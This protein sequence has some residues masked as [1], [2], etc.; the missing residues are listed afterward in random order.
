MSRT[1]YSIHTVLK[2][3]WCTARKLFRSKLCARTASARQTDT[4]VH[5]IHTARYTRTQY[6]LKRRSV[7]E[8]RARTRET[9]GVRLRQG[10]DPPSL[11][12]I[13]VDGPQRMVRAIDHQVREID[14]DGPSGKQQGCFRRKM[15]A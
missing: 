15:D 6:E 9:G 7:S 10:I 5:S 1:A 14:N 12:V 11:G 13:Q 8:G 4:Y 3:A 2:Y